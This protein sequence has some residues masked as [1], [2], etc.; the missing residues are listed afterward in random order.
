M[1]GS[2]KNETSAH[3]E[4]PASTKE[5]G[6]IPASQQAAI[7]KALGLL[8]DAGMD[9]DANTLMKEGAGAAAI[10]ALGG[11]QAEPQ[12]AVE[13]KAKTPESPLPFYKQD[14]FE[15]TAIGVGGVVVGVVGTLAYQRYFGDDENQN[16]QAQRLGLNQGQGGD[17]AYRGPD[18]V[19]VGQP[20]TVH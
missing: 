5:T 14:W 19:D 10:A 8:K 11:K 7:A 1:P 4:A 16:D 6:T 17:N 18:L 20:A 2:N 13:I 15:K 9:V 12:M 3:A